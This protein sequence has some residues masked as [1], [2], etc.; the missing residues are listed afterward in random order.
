MTTP[1]TLN[2]VINTLIE[3]YPNRLPPENIPSEQLARKIGQQDVI[4]Y[5]IQ[6][7]EK[8][9]RRTYA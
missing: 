4:Q 9:E 6:H 8:S 7:L 2:E 3:K 5:L 1:K